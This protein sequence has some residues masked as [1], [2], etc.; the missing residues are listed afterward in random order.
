MSDENNAV[1]ETVEASI[2]TIVTVNRP[3]KMNALNAQTVLASSRA[4]S[5]RSRTTR[6]C[7]LVILTGAGEK[8]FIAGADINELA[9]MKALEAK[10]VAFFGQQV[11]ARLERW[12]SP[13]SR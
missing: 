12:A 2:A 13:R 1:L 9:K 5:T 11:F 4:A 3:K 6:T 10:D 8:A 7:A